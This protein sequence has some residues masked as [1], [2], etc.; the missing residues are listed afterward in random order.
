M[1]EAGPR[2][3]VV[4]TRQPARILPKLP[5]PLRKRIDRKL[6]E[7]ASDPRPQGFKVLQESG[8]CRVRV[9]DWRII[10]SIEDDKVIV[11]V[12]RIAPRGGAY[13]DL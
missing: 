4:L 7:L 10:Y 8:L 3:I 1:S 2:W 9:G 5:P 13:R 11:L 6:L 12:V